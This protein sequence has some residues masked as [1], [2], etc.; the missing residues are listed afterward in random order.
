[1]NSESRYLALANLK[2]AWRFASRRSPRHLCVAH[3]TQRIFCVFYGG[4]LAAML[5]AGILPAS[6]QSV[7]TSSSRAISA[8]LIGRVNLSETDTRKIE[9]ATTAALQDEKIAMLA[10]RLGEAKRAYLVDRK[11]FPAE[12]SADIKR[13]YQQA[14]NEAVAAVRH[15]IN[16]KDPNAAALL[17]RVAGAKGSKTKTSPGEY[18]GENATDSAA[19]NRLAVLPIKD[20]PGLPRVLLIGDSIS[21][22]YTL[23][24]RA[25]LKG[26]AN[27]HRIPVNGGATEVGLA[28]MK[29]WLGDGKWDVIHFNFGLHDAKYASESTQRASREQYAE[30]LRKLVAQMKETGAKLIFATTTPV[31]KDGNLSPTRRF[32]SIPARNELALRMMKENDVAIDDLYAVVLPVQAKLGRSNDVHFEPAGY[33][34][35]AKAVAASIEAQL[36][37]TKPSR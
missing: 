1:M 31:P 8:A 9:A 4:G 35:L 21:I 10:Q 19:K 34:L 29:D 14:L 5:L 33:E 22:G 15:A 25:L 12:R 16:A 18:E 2:V 11:K 30:N 32:D 36:P 24:V 23:Q 20:E 37:N 13:R 26:K 7:D 6:A 3:V 27:V 28:H 17:T